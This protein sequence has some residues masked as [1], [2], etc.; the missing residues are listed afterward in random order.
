MRAQAPHAAV[1]CPPAE[2]VDLLDDKYAF[3]LWMVRSGFTAYVPT[4]FN[5]NIAGT[6][7]QHG[8]STARYIVKK[9]RCS[10]AEESYISSPAADSRPRIHGDY[11]PQRYI[12]GFTEYGSHFCVKNDTVAHSVCLA[13]PC[14]TT[15][16]LRV[17]ATGHAIVSQPCPAVFADLSKHSNY[18]GFACQFQDG[19]W[20]SH[21]I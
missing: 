15:H 17:R 16:I 3:V 5:A 20:R 2:I 19:K 8:P 7:H 10:G 1:F 12:D 13:M 9:V 14:G 21:D 6:Y 18:H 4:L 11:I